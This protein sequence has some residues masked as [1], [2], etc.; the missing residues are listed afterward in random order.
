MGWV[1]H[2]FGDSFTKSGIPN[3]YWPLKYKFV[4]M[5]KI[6]RFVTNGDFERKILLPILSFI[7][8]IEIFVIYRKEISY[9]I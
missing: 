1:L 4:S 8:L 2:I 6:L 7:W 5:P 3:G 9:L